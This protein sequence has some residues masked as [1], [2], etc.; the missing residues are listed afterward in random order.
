MLSVTQT[1]EFAAAHRLHCATMTDEEN[2][3]YFG[4]CNNP[5][6]HGHNYVLEVTVAGAGDAPSPCVLPAARFEQIVKQRVLDRFDH[7]HLNQDCPEFRE[8]NPSVENIARTIW[9]LLDGQFAPARLARVRVWET[10]KTY[11]EYSGPGVG[12]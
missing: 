1:F 7:K 11:A 10:A 12:A 4:K 9:G 3:A 5:N 2:R 8:L 6:G